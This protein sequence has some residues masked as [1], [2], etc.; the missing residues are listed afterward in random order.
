M[1]VVYNIITKLQLK[2]NLYV[3]FIFKM[4]A[5]IVV[6]TTFSIIFKLI[7]IKTIK[8]IIKK[9]IKKE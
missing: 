4:I 3:L 9:K 2:I 5:A 6:Y 8:E 7:D 1:T